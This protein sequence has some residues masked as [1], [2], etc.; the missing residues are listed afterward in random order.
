MCRHEHDKSDPNY[1]YP[2]LVGDMVLHIPNIVVAPPLEEMQA[3]FSKITKSVFSTVRSVPQWGL[4]E[5]PVDTDNYENRA[6]KKSSGRGK[7]STNR[8]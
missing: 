4:D 7:L 2:I 3:Y 8:S 5:M 6:T 1:M